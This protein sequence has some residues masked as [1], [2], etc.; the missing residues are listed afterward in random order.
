[1]KTIDPKTLAKMPQHVRDRLEAATA[2]PAAPAAPAA[3]AAPAAPV[4]P[5]APAPSP[6]ASLAP[7]AASAAPA[8]A[9][10]AAPVVAP[11]PA[12]SAPP[13]PPA[14]ASDID[15]LFGAAKAPTAA[16]PAPAPAAAAIP[17]IP[18]APAPAPAAATGGFR[19]SE[20]SRATYVELLGEEGAALL[21]SDM[22]SL[23]PRDVVSRKDLQDL[24]KKAA[25][26]SFFR[27]LPAEFYSHAATAE[28]D[29]MKW[30]TTTKDGRRSVRDE[31]GAIVASRD[32]DGISYIAEKLEAWQK[33]KGT[34]VVGTH[35]TAPTTQVQ[36]TAEKK[37][38]T[39]QELADM[40]AAIRRG[41]LKTVG[42][43]LSS[44]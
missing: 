37:V 16:A 10:A 19:F 22:A 26:A 35:V 24:D 7:A 33:S 32:A 8:A 31:I 20:K 25:E 18:T 3:A 40:R 43:Q 44:L 2:A 41:D 15:T 1:M 29:F 21:E 42:A 28:T 14:T 38:A 27:A 11:T 36:T 39:G 6:T 13:T 9:P 23:V 12:P 4:A 34:P 17:A 5:A 30:A